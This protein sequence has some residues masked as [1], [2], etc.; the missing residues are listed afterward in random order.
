MGSDDAI[1]TNQILTGDEMNT[2]RVHDDLFLTRC[3]TRRDCL[4]YAGVA[5][6]CA[7]LGPLMFARE[8]NANA[9]RVP[10]YPIDSTVATTAERMIS[11]PINWYAKGNSATDPKNPDN[12]GPGLTA[13]Q[14]SHVSRYDEMGYGAWTFAASLPIVR[15]TDIMPNGHD[16]K[17]VTHTTKILN[18]FT[19]SD[20][21]ITDKEAPNQLIFRQPMEPSL[22]VMLALYAP[23]M[24]YTTHVLDAAIQTVNALHK[25]NPFD[26]GL[27]LGDACN[28]TSNNELRWYIDV[29][30]GK[31]IT[32]S[33]GAHLG[34]GTIDYQKTYQAAGLD[35][36]IPWY[37]AMGNHDHFLIGSFPVDADPSLGLRESYVSDT[38]WSVANV[39]V[40]DLARFPAMFDMKNLKAEPRYYG[41]VL[42]GSTPSGTIIDAGPVAQFGA[43]PKIAADPGR[44]SLTRTQWRKEFFTT[45]SEPKGHGF[46]LVDPAQE[47]G[48][49]CYSFV[50]KA[51]VPL[52]IIVLD[53][54]QSETDGS[55]DV[56]GHGY[57]DERRLA[58]LQKE[59]KAGQEDNQLMIVAAHV[60]IAV[61]NIGTETEWWLGGKTQ[62]N[63]LGD[64]STTTQNAVDLAGL[65]KTLQD[66]PN[67]LMWVAG[68]RHLNTVKAFVSHDPANAPEKGF[69]QVET[70]S[71]RDFPQQFRTFEI[72]LNSDYSISIVTTNVDPAVA[73]GTPAATSRKYAI[74]AQQIAQSDLTRNSPNVATVGRAPHTLSVPSMDPTRPQGTPTLQEPF[75]DPSIQFV[76]LS[77][78]G[79][80]Y[81]ASY[82]A[83]LFKQLSPKMV[84]VL[85]AKY[86]L[87]S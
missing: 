28:S 36:S 25:K 32:P 33:S 17:A 49:T 30:D 83:E 37:Q 29:I 67:L 45:S 65:V 7:L 85:K 84:D 4:K 76:D 21:H 35:K 86:P 11:F 60:P 22:A 69:W 15:R 20:I 16:A 59:L 78:Q 68:H 24:A 42:D 80:P 40:P 43:P 54:T 47:E 1:N 31:L 58:W 71:L 72:H 66:A 53:D 5:L 19:I 2:V 9:T 70:S 27:S 61:S 44:R 79:V 63:P 50:P 73:Q 62:D 6:T 34:A 87:R 38:V 82:N 52:K 64:G 48:F 57:L 77:A 39:L 81:N 41:G 10:S 14:L 75:T 56:H 23:Y 18:F 74:A 12:T 3:V 51:D 8:G 46:H 55:T 26:F 13:A